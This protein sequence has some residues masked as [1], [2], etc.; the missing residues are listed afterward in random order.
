MRGLALLVLLV[1]S[2]S[3][4]AHTRS[5]SYAHWVLD[6]TGGAV[7]LR[8]SQLDLSRL[9]LDPSRTPDY[10]DAVAAQVTGDLQLWSGDQP[11]VPDV[12]TVESAGE[13]WL[14][15][16]WRVACPASPT[17][18]QTG[19]F[20]AVAP[21][22]LHFVWLRTAE[23]EERHQV[24]GYAEPVLWLDTATETAGAGEAGWR[25]YFQI[26]VVH[27][28]G[29][30]DH[31]LFLFVLLL[32]AR[33]WRDLVWLITAFTL[34]HSVSLAASVLGGL[35]VQAR[36]VEG[37]I[38]WSILLVAAEALWL[39][40]GRDPWIPRIAVLALLAAALWNGAGVPGTLWGGMILVT[41]CYFGLLDRS[42]TPL[43]LRAGLVFA[44]GLVHGLGFAGELLAL[45]L[46]RE[47][48]AVALL[49]FNLG[50]EAGQLLLIA[51]LWPLL[52]W[53][54]AQARREARAVP[55][56]ALLAIVAS[57]QAWCLRMV[58]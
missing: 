4:Q 20:A 42:E 52:A 30:W 55:V 43:R 24:L 54:R 47:T 18:L 31:L 58:L 14:S 37:L 33:R 16:H 19:L 3:L 27:I 34:S 53:M 6:Q 12:A 25:R 23:G 48:L 50:V 29:G 17:A 9:S 8:V 46:P 45:A 15:L 32:L 10:R 39:R 35:Q 21:S 44:F 26:G 57:A 36:W 56:L 49:G 38:A 51:L 13:G 41:A 22:H 28:L 1:I 11:C 2:A 7:Q 5:A 40:A